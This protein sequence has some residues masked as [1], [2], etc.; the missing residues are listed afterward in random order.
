MSFFI[1]LGIVVLAMLIMT[2]LQLTPGTF[3]L[4]SHYTRGK[5]SKSRASDMSIFFILGVE[6]A[7][8]CLFLSCYFIANLLFL[9]QFRPES[10][11]FAWIAIGVLIA[12]GFLSIFCYFRR[13]RGTS[14]FISRSLASRIDTLARSAKSRSDSFALGAFSVL[15]ELPFTFPLY[16]I[17]SVEIMEMSIEFAPSHFLTL[18]Y[19][20]IPTIQLFIIR[21]NF[22]SGRNIVDLQ[23]SR[24]QHK[25]FTRTILSCS[26]FAI[27]M[28]IIYFRIVS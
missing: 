18:I 22:A 28:L 23:K 15:P 10:S 11:F 5:Y 14:L 26:Y 8:A 7:S 19:I 9:Y 17:T 16:V 27:A 6:V 2:F 25:S 24:V 13:G 3:M 21:W 1:S 20:L 4:F 12:L